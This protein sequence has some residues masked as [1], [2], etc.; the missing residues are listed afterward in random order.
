MGTHLTAGQRALIADQL[1]SR[2][3]TLERQ[4][5]AHQQGLSRAEHAREVL[6]QD[7]DDAPQRASDREVDMAL[8]DQDLHELGAVSLALKRVH[9]EQFGE[10][11]DCHEAIPFDRLKAEPQA[12]RC[13]ACESLHERKT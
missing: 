12:L 6:V 5:M 10:C 9:D 13:V 1:R 3:Q 2:Q 7:G 11:I 8:S 4:L